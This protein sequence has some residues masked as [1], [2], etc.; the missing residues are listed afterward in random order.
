VGFLDLRLLP[1]LRRA[2]AG[3]ARQLL[4]QDFRVLVE[5]TTAVDRNASATSQAAWTRKN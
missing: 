2:R 3:R 1:E 4:G 5:Q